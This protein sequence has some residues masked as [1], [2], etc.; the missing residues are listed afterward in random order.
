MN[1]C[2]NVLFWSLSRR[3][4]EVIFLLEININLSYTACWFLYVCI[5]LGLLLRIKGKA[6]AACWKVSYMPIFVLHTTTQ[7]LTN[8]CNF[9]DLE[10]ITRI[11]QE[12]FYSYSCGCWPIHE[13]QVL[14]LPRFS[15]RASLGRDQ[16]SLK[17][18][19]NYILVYFL[20]GHLNGGQ[21]TGCSHWIYLGSQ[22]WW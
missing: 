5:L 22:A 15:W 17:Q 13:S 21:R 12:A 2:F 10:Q 18:I 4:L 3:N 7:R 8:Y 1:L 6:F 14:L 19:L 9:N 20:C 16:Y 11:F